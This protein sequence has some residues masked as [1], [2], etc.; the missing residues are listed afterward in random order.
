M[1]GMDTEPK[2]SE[3]VPPAVPSAAENQFSVRRAEIRADLLKWLVGS[4]ALTLITTIGNW[5]FQAF[6]LRAEKEKTNRELQIKEK[7]M[8]LQYLDKFTQLAID[9][10][11]TKRIR[12]AHYISR[13]IDD[14]EFKQLAK[15]WN[16]YY[17]E[18][19]KACNARLRA[20][21]GRGQTEVQAALGDE[22]ACTI[23]GTETI[24]PVQLRRPSGQPPGTQDE[25]NAKMS[26][27]AASFV[28][29]STANVPG[30]NSGRLAEAWSVNEIARVALG[31]AISGDG[32]DDNGLSIGQ[33]FEVLKSRH[34]QRPIEHVDPGMII[35]SPTAG[36]VVGHIGIIGK[37]LA[38]DPGNF[39]IYSNSSSRA[40]FQQNYTLKSWKSNFEQ[41]RG[42]GNIRF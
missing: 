42:S 6:S 33:L 1:S 27:I 8:Q 12:L 32:A 11:I 35:V 16:D 36:D 18:L 23:G 24:R 9:Q 20:A 17:A 14:Q 4:V 26:E 28:G 22:P 39:V 25:V 15:R 2:G 31:R 34:I 30:T 37:S 7:D 5:T 41:R 13:T 10:D 21:Q 3:A 19:S 38:D 29:Y 40:A